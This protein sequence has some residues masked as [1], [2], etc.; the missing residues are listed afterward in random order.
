MRSNHQ[1][2]M[3]DLSAPSRD[4]ILRIMG[5]LRQAVESDDTIDRKWMLELSKYVFHI[6]GDWHEKVSTGYREMEEK[7][8]RLEQV[9]W[10][11]H[12]E[13]RDRLNS[14]QLSVNL[15]LKAANM[16][17]DA[18]FKHKGDQNAKQGIDA[19]SRSAAG[20]RG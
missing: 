2:S 6:V 17:F 12:N 1:I 8:E 4:D 20:D 9:I 13:N 18:H 5:E 11:I 15:C 14:Q 3:A 16:V 10:S 7:V 19:V